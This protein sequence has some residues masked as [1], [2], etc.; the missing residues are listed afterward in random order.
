MCCLKC[1]TQSHLQLLSTRLFRHIHLHSDQGM[2]RLM[3]LWNSFLHTNKVY[4]LR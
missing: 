4:K 2:A 3:H 1:M